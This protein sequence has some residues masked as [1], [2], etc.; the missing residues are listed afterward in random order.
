MLVA[1]TPHWDELRAVGSPSSGEVFIHLDVLEDGL[2]G[3]VCE[4]LYADLRGCI[5]DADNAHRLRGS[6]ECAANAYGIA[7]LSLALDLSLIGEGLVGLIEILTTIVLRVEDEEL[8]I[9]YRLLLFSGE[10]A[11]GSL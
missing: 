10:P 6:L 7:L 11:Q 4:V 5:G 3:L 2:L 8:D 1:F 9:F